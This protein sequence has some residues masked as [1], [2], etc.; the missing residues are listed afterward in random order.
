MNQLIIVSHFLST[1]ALMGLI[2]T[3]QCVHYPSF[4]Y[5]SSE[6]FASFHRF[7][8]QQIT[9]IVAPLMLVE[10]LTATIL[11]FKMPSNFIFIN[12]AS[13]M[14]IWLLTAFV[15]VPLHKQLSQGLQLDLI[16]KLIATNWPRTILWTLRAFI[17]GYLLYKSDIA[18][19]KIY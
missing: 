7:H 15:S 10:I 9:A 13:V 11:C 2:W 19:I 18:E 17:W 8:T 3:I 5:V 12:F 6:N 14:L 1:F 4:R 16:N